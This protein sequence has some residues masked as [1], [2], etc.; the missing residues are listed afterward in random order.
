[1][2]FIKQQQIYLSDRQTKKKVMQSSQAEPRS[3][4]SWGSEHRQPL[5]HHEQHLQIKKTEETQRLIQVVI[6]PSWPSSSPPTAILLGEALCV[7]NGHSRPVLNYLH[8]WSGVKP[9]H[10]LKDSFGSFV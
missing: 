2:S 7:T 4:L 6:L 9:Q 8:R 10:H 5:V 3:V 1:M